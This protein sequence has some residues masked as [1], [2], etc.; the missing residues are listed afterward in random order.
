MSSRT[1]ELFNQGLDFFTAVLTQVVDDDWER[2]SP[3]AGWTAR[4]LL[5]HLASTVWS[6]ISMMQ[7][8]EPSWPDPTRPGDLVEGDPV[9]FWRD[10]VLRAQQVLADADLT[11]PMESPLG[12]TVA[13]ALA[14]PVIDLYVHAWDLA[15]TINLVREIPGTVIAYAHDHL[16]QV[17]EEIIRGENRAFAPK[18]E[19][20]A[21]ATPTEE[22]L[23][24]TGRQLLSASAVLRQGDF[25]LGRR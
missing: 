14:I 1:A 8:I 12:L 13:D 18:A 15:A 7:G 3:C 17:P 10:T 19:T 5:G 22:F 23:A 21:D 6:A 20:P 24:W 4:D 9:K 2:P 25:P 11:R 16:D